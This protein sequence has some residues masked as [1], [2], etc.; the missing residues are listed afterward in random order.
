MSVSTRC[1]P[2]PAFLLLPGPSSCP[3]WPSATSA[4]SRCE[5]VS[6]F[7]LLP[8]LSTCP[9]WPSATSVA[10]RC[11]PVPAFL[12]LPEPFTCPAWPSAT[13]TSA[14]CE[15]FSPDR[16]TPASCASGSC[17]GTMVASA[18]EQAASAML[19]CWAGGCPLPMRCHTVFPAQSDIIKSVTIQATSSVSATPFGFAGWTYAD[20]R[21]GTNYG[22]PL[23]V[24]K[25]NLGSDLEDAS[26]Y[27][28][29][30]SPGDSGHISAYLVPYTGKAHTLPAGATLIV[31]LRTQSTW[32]SK[33]AT[34]LASGLTLEPGKMC[35]INVDMTE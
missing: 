19:L 8:D 33:S 15:P 18:R 20:N 16:L 7:P 25:L 14:R 17:P 11:E 27:G 26:T 24:L 34:P 31:Q 12:L 1:E 35:R 6:A 30:I 10:S 3:A 5:P 29:G 23:K 21:F 32:S 2:V 13:Y 4:A 22:N 9:A 28:T